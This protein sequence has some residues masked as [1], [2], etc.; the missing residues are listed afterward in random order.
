MVFITSGPELQGRVSSHPRRQAAGAASSS[1]KVKLE[2]DE[3]PTIKPAEPLMAAWD[4]LITLQ[5]NDGIYVVQVAALHTT[6]QKVQRAPQNDGANFTVSI[7]KY[8]PPEV[9]MMGDDA[10]FEASSQCIVALTPP[11]REEL[12]IDSYCVFLYEVCR[13]TPQPR[14]KSSQTPR[15]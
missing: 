13:D 8:S 14:R 1:K 6:L 9:L 12:L 3:S 11:Q 10:E 2:R 15:N 5:S 4:D 7:P